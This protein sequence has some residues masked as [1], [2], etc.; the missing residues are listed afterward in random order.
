MLV[1][2]GL[3]PPLK[4]PEPS[5]RYTAFCWLLK[6]PTA[7]SRSPSPSAS[8]SVV[9]YVASPAG[10]KFFD[11]SVNTAGPVPAAAVNSHTCGSV[12][13]SLASLLSPIVDPAVN[14]TSTCS[15]GRKSLAGSNTRSVVP[16]PLNTPCRF[17]VI[18]PCATNPC[19]V[20]PL[21]ASL[22]V[23]LTFDV[24]NTAMSF[25]AGNTV[26]TVG[27][28][29]SVIGIAWSMVTLVSTLRAPEGHSTTT[30][31]TVAV[32]PNPNSTGREG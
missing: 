9:L 15:P 21:I 20:P 25:S 12:S 8:P 19:T 1:P 24:D 26:T 6:F 4:V 14:T 29:G 16:S 13:A 10:P 2:K 28:D 30:E 7:T 22:N 17:P 23:A 27:A 11:T 32:A 3:V 5:L 18:E 31:S